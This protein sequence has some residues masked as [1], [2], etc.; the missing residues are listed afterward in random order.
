MYLPEYTFEWNDGMYQN[1]LMNEALQQYVPS[2][3]GVFKESASY[4]F[5]DAS[6]F[7]ISDY[8]STL[9]PIYGIGDA[10]QELLTEEQWKERGY[11]ESGI[12]YKEGVTDRQAQI[13]QER[14]ERDRFY[15]QYM[16]HTSMLSVGGIAGMVAG[17]LPDPINYIP[18][19]G[20]AGRFA[21]I[22]RIASKMPILAMSANAMIGQATFETIKQSHYK[23]LG[24]D[25]DWTAV[26]VDIGI[27]GT[28][29]AGFGG[30]AKLGGLRKSLATASPE[31]HQ[32]NLAIAATHIGD[33]QPVEVKLQGLYDT[34]TIP[35]FT[36]KA[37]RNIYDD[38]LFVREQEIKT[39]E[40]AFDSISKEI[41]PEITPLARLAQEEEATI[42]DTLRKTKSCQAGLI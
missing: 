13:L 15:G 4:A 12:Q 11:N 36:I 3:F 14:A 22:A 31:V 27:A 23:S 24:R 8:L 28:L 10:E 40:H 39:Q 1:V 29:G 38:P 16:Q 2:T 33:Q 17:S 5:N 9:E 21:K 35:Q 34:E 32:N 7:H 20:W 37:S 19:I 25:V 26:F 41:E 18:F 42:A 6:F 30:L